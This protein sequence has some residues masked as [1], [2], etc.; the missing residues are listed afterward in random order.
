MGKKKDDDDLT[1]P[2]FLRV[3]N[4]KAG[5][6]TGPAKRA[7]PKGDSRKADPL[8]ILSVA[9][10]MRIEPLIKSGKFR[11]HWLEDPSIVAGVEEQTVKAEQRKAE[12]LEHFKTLPR[13]EPKPKKPAF[14]VG[15]VIKVLKEKSRKPGT[16][17]A[18]IYEEMV[19]FVKKNPGCDVSQIISETHYTKGFY[20]ADIKM[21]NI[22]ADVK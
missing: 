21:G 4:R 20:L 3:E 18:A 22:K 6:A 5:P 16:T 8:A 19:K 9:S 7:V 2:D 14:G 12:R 15:V 1:I 11:I 17:A 10:R 13:K